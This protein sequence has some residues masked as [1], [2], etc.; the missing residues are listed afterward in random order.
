MK[1]D[2]LRTYHAGEVLCREGDPGTELFFIQEGRV[3]VSRMMNGE[4]IILAELGANSIVGE[5][6]VIDQSP[7][8]ASVTALEPTQVVSMSHGKL[9][10]V[11]RNAPDIAVSI[12]KLLCLKLR[13][14]NDRIGRGFS[15]HDW[16]FWRRTIYLF[17]LLGAVS[18][19]HAENI[20]IPDEEARTN[21]SVGL[22]LS[23][24]ETGQVVDRLISSGLI[25]P[26]TDADNAPYLSYRMTEFNMFYTFLDRY[27]GSGQQGVGA[28]MSSDTFMVSSRLLE[29]CRKHFGRIELASSTFKRGT[30]VEFI[31]SDGE[32]FGKHSMDM[33]KKMIDEQLDI[34]AGLGF[35]KGEQS[36]DGGVSLELVAL[37][38]RIH[39]EQYIRSCL[40][41]YRILSAS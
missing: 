37:A 11:F 23:L 39:E 32:V 7:R 15:M 18:D 31:A 19:S 33:R 28:D 41:R 5:M 2:L 10:S 30:L 8:S 40:E 13:E 14:T 27:F 6:A 29:L 24:Q 21:L 17:T 36:M 38:Q 25:R 3:K 12:V 26:T 1:K 22:G 16:V 20:E 34:L 4:E 35:L 9:D